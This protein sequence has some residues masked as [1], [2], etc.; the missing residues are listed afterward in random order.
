MFAW[1]KKLCGHSG[2][3]RKRKKAFEPNLPFTPA[4]LPPRRSEPQDG[5]KKP[6]QGMVVIDCVR[7]FPHVFWVS[8]LG[9]DQ[10]FPQG[11][12]Y[13][14]LAVRQEPE[15]KVDAV[16]FRELPDGTKTELLRFG[17]A[18][19]A[20]APDSM[21]QDLGRKLSITF[22]R[23]DLSGIKTYPEFETM[24]REMGWGPL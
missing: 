11:F 23:F 1:L 20:F 8:N 19:D 22:E 4:Q 12:R 6:M 21:I 7:A 10:E 16:L 17:G 5:K 18:R 9:R 15:G 14:I 24:A 13:K 3:H 2:A